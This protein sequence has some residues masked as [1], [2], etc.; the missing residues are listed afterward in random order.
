MLTYFFIYAQLAVVTT[1]FVATSIFLH[2]AHNFNVSN[3]TL[4]IITIII[5]II[6]FNK[7]C[8]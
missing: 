8:I 4:K 6:Y 1:S 7:I 3:S 5:I 2:I